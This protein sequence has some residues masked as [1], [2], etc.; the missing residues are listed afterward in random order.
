VDKAK[1]TYIYKV[2]DDTKLGLNDYIWAPNF[3][4]SSLDS[5]VM[6]MEPNSWMSGIDLGEF[7]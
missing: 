3:Y 1:G 7:F 2:Y 4:V 5:L 6:L